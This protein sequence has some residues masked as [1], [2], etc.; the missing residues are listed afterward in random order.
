MAPT[1]Q[2][3][4][5][6]GRRSGQGVSRLTVPVREQ[7]AKVFRGPVDPSADLPRGR[8]LAFP[9]PSAD[10]LRMNS[11]DLRKVPIADR[12]R[13][14]GNRGSGTH[15]VQSPRCG[16][17]WRWPPIRPF[18]R[19][20]TMYYRQL[21]GTGIRTPS[22]FSSC[23]EIRGQVCAH[24]CFR[25]WSCIRPFTSRQNRLC[26]WVG[27]GQAQPMSSWPHFFRMGL[28]TIVNKWRYRLPRGTNP[29]RGRIPR[30]GGPGIPW[31]W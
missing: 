21:R 27:R 30:Y 6:A 11:Q 23:R 13:Q 12:P 28:S 17:G 8:D 19:P 20:Y 15:S 7:R 31:P 14:L 1:P 2:L 18:T 5:L 25:R 9:S 22:N 3:D 29:N 10:R 4:A 16:G 26:L 24:G